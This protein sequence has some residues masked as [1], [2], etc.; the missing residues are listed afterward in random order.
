MLFTSREKAFAS[1]AVWAMAC[2]LGCSDWTFFILKKNMFVH[3]FLDWD[4]KTKILN[5]FFYFNVSPLSCI[6]PISHQRITKFP[7]LK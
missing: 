2:A 6:F 5:T 3:A 1:P 7:F 4:C